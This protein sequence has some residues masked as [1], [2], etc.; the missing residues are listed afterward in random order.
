MSA[1]ENPET[2]PDTHEA[3]D[4]IR[5]RKG[6]LAFR[7]I[8]EVADELKVP[9]HVLRFWETRFEQ[10]RPLKRGGGRRYYRPEDVDLL[11]RIATLLYVKGYT[12]KGV[13]RVLREKG[14]EGL[15]EEVSG[16]AADASG[17]E[18]VSEPDICQ[19]QDDEPQAVAPPLM[20]AVQPE[21][22]VVTVTVRD[23]RLENEH[24]RMRKSLEDILLRLAEVKAS[25]TVG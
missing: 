24:D 7:T 5:G 14:P 9:Q 22:Q 25:L 18:T 20:Q 11:R 2:A 10:V 13:Q 6:P 15:E 4:E 23:E 17:S 1:G 12:I 19:S 16:K 21:P 3:D 8:S